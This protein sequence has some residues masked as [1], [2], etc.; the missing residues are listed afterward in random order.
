MLNG[1]A[2]ST[3]FAVLLQVGGVETLGALHSRG[4]PAILAKAGDT[5]GRAYHAGNRMR[6]DQT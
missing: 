6:P 3:P 2:S 1:R 5:A 4:G